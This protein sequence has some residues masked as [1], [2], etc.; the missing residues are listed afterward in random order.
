MNTAPIALI[1]WVPLQHLWVY[2][3]NTSVMSAV[4]VG[5]LSLIVYIVMERTL[6]KF[7]LLVKPLTKGE[8][9]ANGFVQGLT[10][11]N[12]GLGL[13]LTFSGVFGLIASGGGRDGDWSLLLALGSS[14]LGY[15]GYAVC[16]LAVVVDAAPH[17]RRRTTR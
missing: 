17:P 8:P 15:S 4:Q 6:R 5:L 3:T 10:Q 7:R 12:M 1:A 11:L 13:L 16:A 2:L 9:V 14:A